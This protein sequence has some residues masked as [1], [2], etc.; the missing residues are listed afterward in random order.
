MSNPA[1]TAEEDTAAYLVRQLGVK[2]VQDINL[3]LLEGL[4]FYRKDDDLLFAKL[5]ERQ[6]AFRAFWQRHFG[7]DLVV[8]ENVAYRRI[9]AEGEDPGAGFRNPN[10]ATSQRT[11]LNWG[12]PGK[13][14]RSVTFMLFLQFYESE[15]RRR[16][17]HGYGERRFFPHEFYR[18]V[19]DQFTRWFSER[20]ESKP[21]D[22][23]LFEAVREVF[24]TLETYRFIEKEKGQ[25]DEI[26]EADRVFLPRGFEG[27]RVV[28]YRALEGLRGYDPHT[29]TESVAL[30]AYPAAAPAPEGRDD[31]GKA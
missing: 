24:A 19:Q 10:I 11:I 13:R 22:H 23:A 5:S 8:E 2:N 18:F 7:I 1:G 27:E 21:T 3:L 25:A 14:E 30:D 31:D 15:L 9:V 28:I 12:G 16:E 20:Q 6:S 29:L 17:D 26:T 4:F